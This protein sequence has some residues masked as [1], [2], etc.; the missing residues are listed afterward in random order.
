MHVMYTQQYMKQAKRQPN[1]YQKQQQ[2]GQRKYLV[3]AVNSLELL[4]GRQ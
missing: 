4:Q 2:P 3:Q 1:E